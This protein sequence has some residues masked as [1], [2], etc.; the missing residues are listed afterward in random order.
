MSSTTLIK[1]ID[2]YLCSHIRG[3]GKE[4]NLNSKRLLP[5]NIRIVNANLLNVEEYRFI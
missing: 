5:N 3:L 1:N 4:T 2:G